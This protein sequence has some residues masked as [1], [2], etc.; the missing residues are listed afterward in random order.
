[1][2]LFLFL[3]SPALLL[4]EVFT[5]KDFGERYFRLSSVLTV[6]AVLGFLPVLLI[7]LQAM[8]GNSSAVADVYGLDEM[9]E[10]AQV[11]APAAKTSLMPDYLCWYIFLALFLALGIKHK[12][13][14]A[15]N[16][17]VFDFAKFSLYRGNV[18][19]FF[20]RMK[21]PRIET[22]P[23]IVEC[24]LEPVAFFIV[25]LFFYLIGQKLGILLIVTSLLYAYSYV[26][27][28][29]HG[30]NFVMDKIDQM[31]SNEELEAAFVLDKSDDETRGFTFRG[32]KPK[33]ETMRREILPL[34]TQ[35]DD[36]LEAK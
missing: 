17:S 5:R 11:Y 33:T 34:F 16:P 27:F 26:A 35:Q 15:R 7:K 9:G 3:A 29:H 8:L 20:Y 2:Q 22:T 13:D 10:M 23:R 4:I 31:I 1:M 14:L 12:I 18:H 28:Y 25:G 32:R 30:D 19:P 24:I 6:T 21:L 36:V